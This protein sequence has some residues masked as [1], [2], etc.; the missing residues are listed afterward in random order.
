MGL[1]WGPEIWVWGAWLPCLNEL[2]TKSLAVFY[3]LG[4]LYQNRYQS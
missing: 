2:Q 3:D 1:V 4:R